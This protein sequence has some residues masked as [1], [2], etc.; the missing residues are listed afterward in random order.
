MKLLLL[1][2]MIIMPGAL[3]A[4]NTIEIPKMTEHYVVM[5]ISPTIKNTTIYNIDDGRGIKTSF[6]LDLYKEKK[7][8]ASYDNVLASALNQF[9]EQGFKLINSYYQENGTARYIF[10]KD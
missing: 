6:E 10:Q 7:Y 3:T 5:S 8:T 1:F 9:Y 4:Q 2:L